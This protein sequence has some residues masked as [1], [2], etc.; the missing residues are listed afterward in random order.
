[1]ALVKAAGGFDCR[2]V[3]GRS[4]RNSNGPSSF[5]VGLNCWEDDLGN[6]AYD[7][8]TLQTLRAVFD[9]RG[10]VSHP[11]TEVARANR[12]WR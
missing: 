1:V 10:P 6:A 3:K 2:M 9:E 7:P 4:E 5:D 11:R 8:E 12:K